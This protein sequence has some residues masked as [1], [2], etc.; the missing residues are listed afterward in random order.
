MP[1]LPTI[2][3]I[4]S[5]D[6]SLTTVWLVA[7]VPTVVAILLISSLGASFGRCQKFPV[8]RS[9]VTARSPPLRISGVKR[10]ALMPP[11][12]FLVVVLG[13]VALAEVAHQRAVGVLH[14]RG[15]RRAPLVLV[16]ERHE[17]V[18]EPGHRAGHA[19]AAHVRAAADAV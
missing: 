9:S 18:R 3:V 7:G 14:G 17:L 8:T 4:G 19:D 13:D 2:R 11:L 10:A 1:R 15:R 6:I 16:H 12:G 5:H